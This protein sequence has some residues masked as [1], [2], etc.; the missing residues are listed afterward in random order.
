MAGLIIIQDIIYTHIYMYR[1]SFRFIV[2][3]E[4]L[5]PGMILAGQ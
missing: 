5:K 3:S 4:G 2:F 1:F